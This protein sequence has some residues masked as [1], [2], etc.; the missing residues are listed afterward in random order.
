MSIIFFCSV[1]VL[2][3]IVLSWLVHDSCCVFLLSLFLVPLIRPFTGARK[4]L[5][6]KTI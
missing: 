1:F 5:F 4:L 6:C 3:S 2:L